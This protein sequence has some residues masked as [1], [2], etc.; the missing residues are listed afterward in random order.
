MNL[1]QRIEL[2]KCELSL[3]PVDFI[4]KHYSSHT[5]YD[6]SEAKLKKALEHIISGKTLEYVATMVYGVPKKRF[7]QWMNDHSELDHAIQCA[8]DYQISMVWQTRENQWLE[9][10]D[11]APTSSQVALSDRA[12]NKRFHNRQIRLSAKRSIEQNLET[13]YD[14]LADGT[15]DEARASSLINSLTK[16]NND[17]E[18]RAQV[19]SIRNDLDRVLQEKNQKIDELMGKLEL[20]KNL[21]EQA[22]NDFV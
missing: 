7:C 14:A 5:K 21:S 15:I 8:L 2:E 13:I 9:H 20:V 10:P 4:L 17:V 6:P 11:D 19:D 16:Y 3:K 22:S 1:G 12:F 18:T